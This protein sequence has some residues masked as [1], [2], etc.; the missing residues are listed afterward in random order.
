MFHMVFGMQKSFWMTGKLHSLTKQRMLLILFDGITILL[1]E[2]LIRKL[3]IP[4]YLFKS[5]AIAQNIRR[6]CRCHGVSGSCEFKTCWLQM[7][8]FSQVSDLLKKRYDHFAV[9][10]EL[11]DVLIL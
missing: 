5:Q 3:C 1:E 4:I 11:E 10:V 8:K 9:Q 7:Q 6:Q 2:R